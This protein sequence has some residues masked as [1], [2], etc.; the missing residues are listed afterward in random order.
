MPD[1]TAISEHIIGLFDD[2]NDWWQ[3]GVIGASIIFA[4]L[5]RKTL[6]FVFDT[7]E[8]KFYY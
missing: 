1:F 6:K 3:W 2:S 7:S 8:S 5:L 4:Y